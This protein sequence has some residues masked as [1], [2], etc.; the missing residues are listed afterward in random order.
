MN[1]LE[2]YNTENTNLVSESIKNSNQILTIIIP[3]YNR[4]KSLILT[5]N[6]LRLIADKA[7]LI[8]MIIDNAS[9]NYDFPFVSNLLDSMGFDYLIYRNII[10]LG[11]G[12]SFN[13]SVLLSSTNYFMY[14]FD[15]DTVRFELNYAIDEIKDTKNG[16]YFFN[17]FELI[18]TKKHSI[19]S[20]TSAFV[21]NTLNKIAL[22]K[23]VV[24]DYS[25]LLT[26]PSFIGAIYHRDAFLNI[27]GFNLTK[28]PTG[29][30]E[31][32]IRY[33]E[34]YGLVRF[35]YQVI[36]YRHG[37]NDSSNPETNKLFPIDNYK[38]RCEL[39]N[40]LDLSEEKK[41]K[42]LKLIIERKAFEE[43]NI[44]GINKIKHTLITI[45]AYLNL[46]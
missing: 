11:S 7:K 36:N 35:K 6:S 1:R 41:G 23:L 28:G 10:N 29:D 31:F 22:R 14:L 27:G 32:T 3:T 13:L 30:Y 18:N 5:L 19:K 46:I 34:S 17:K 26:V 15:D 39:L 43:K 4:F 2:N 21:R 40:R 16:L 20:K 37:D 8:I 44:R 42:L 24:N 25:I 45:G 9:I 38:Y 33:W 12:Y